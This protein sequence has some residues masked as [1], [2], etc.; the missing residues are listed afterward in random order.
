[1]E[2]K[3]D[4][5]TEAPIMFCHISVA[6]PLLLTV[7]RSFSRGEDSPTGG[8]FDYGSSENGRKVPKV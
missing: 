5:D 7:Q 1:M 3:K 6:L 4:L 2:Q 8:A